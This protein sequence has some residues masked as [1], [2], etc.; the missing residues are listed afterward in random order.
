MN[1]KLDGF[2][3]IRISSIKKEENDNI[4]KIQKLLIPFKKSEIL[5]A[6]PI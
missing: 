1:P 2:D 6:I 5:Q 4:Y 3:A